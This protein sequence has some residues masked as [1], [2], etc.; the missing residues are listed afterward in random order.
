MDWHPLR[1]SSQESS[2]EQ[3]V[4]GIQ[5]PPY[6]WKA[7]IACSRETSPELRAWFSRRQRKWKLP[8]RNILVQFTASHRPSMLRPRLFRIGNSLRTFRRSVHSVPNLIHDFREGIPGLLSPQGFDMAWTQY[9]SLMLE[10]LSSL[11]AGM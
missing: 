9:Q 7:E 11:T 2:G 3:R 8:L 5:T 4:M 1:S 6:H 10:K